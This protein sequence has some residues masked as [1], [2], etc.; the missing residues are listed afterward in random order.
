[1]VARWACRVKSTAVCD[2][3]PRMQDA[4]M[5]LLRAAGRR[6]RNGALLRAATK[7]HK[8][9]PGLSAPQTN[10][11]HGATCAG[12]LRTSASFMAQPAGQDRACRHR[13]G[14]KRAR[15]TRAAPRPCAQAR[16]RNGGC[17]RRSRTSA[18]RISGRDVQPAAMRPRHVHP[19][20]PVG[21]SLAFE[22]VL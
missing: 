1:M 12:A 19:D 18:E 15:R 8:E 10:C 17:L 4:C 13:N 14:A 6:P 2:E 16:E 9:V 11:E 5:L 21:R 7:V 3:S 22:A 20:P